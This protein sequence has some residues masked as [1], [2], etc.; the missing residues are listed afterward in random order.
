MPF[1][2]FT[3]FILLAPNSFAEIEFTGDTGNQVRVK[4]DI[5]I[6]K[7]AWSIGKH[8]FKT[9]YKSFMDG[10]TC[11]LSEIKA[12]TKR[13]S[14]KIR[15]GTKLEIDGMTG[16]YSGR[17]F[18]PRSF[19]LKYAPHEDP[20]TSAEITENADNSMEFNF[21]CKFPG[22]LTFFDIER[23]N[24]DMIEEAMKDYLEFL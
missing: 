22:E 23:S 4:K 10:Y 6:K 14:L 19:T 13:D 16:S 17:R 9:K 11:R 12:S 21:Y 1:L 20:M 2:I 5:E 8:V 15:R 18:Q 7:G 24:R 3:F